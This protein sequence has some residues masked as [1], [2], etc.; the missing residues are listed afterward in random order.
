MW[1]NRLIGVSLAAALWTH[2]VG[3]RA[4]PNGIGC[5]PRHS[6]RPLADVGLFDGPP[7]ER[8]ELV[9]RDG[10]WDLDEPGSRMLPNF[11]LECTYR[12][13]KEAVT[14]VLPR[15]VRVCAFRH[16]PQVLCH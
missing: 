9:P 13:S 2:T 5:P 12:G 10:G 11:T 15:G 16:Y 7:S 1:S 4:E 8:V 14:I 3:V 6:G